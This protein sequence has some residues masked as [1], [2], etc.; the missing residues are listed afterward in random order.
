MKPKKKHPITPRADI[1]HPRFT[2]IELLVV[3]AIIAI[4]AAMLLPALNKARE[5][6]R[7]ANCLSNLKQLTLGQ[8]SYA[9]DYAGY[10]VHSVIY[11]TKYE[12]Y[13]TLLA[14]SGSISGLL[15]QG[16]GYLNWRSMGCPSVTGDKVLRSADNGYKDG[17]TALYSVYGVYIGYNTTDLSKPGIVKL[18][19]EL[20]DFVNTSS[21]SSWATRTFSTK[22]MRKPTQTAIAGDCASANLSNS[23][24]FNVQGCSFS[25]LGTAQS[26]SRMAIIRRHS[27]QANMGY[28]DG[29]AA[30]RSGDQLLQ[31]SMPFTGGTYSPDLVLDHIETE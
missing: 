6:G 26:S 11:G 10:M 27:N 13:A 18:I 5:R 23:K 29:H 12:N 22:K 17:N 2:M 9:S 20:G 21:A 24:F 31:G 4:L 7:A 1:A 3:I 16:G 8:S 28:A 14:R 15:S 25:T 19:E 30:S